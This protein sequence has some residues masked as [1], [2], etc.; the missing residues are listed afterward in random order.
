VKRLW[1]AST[2]PADRGAP[3]RA[4]GRICNCPS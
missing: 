1:P 2:A 4:P 3:A